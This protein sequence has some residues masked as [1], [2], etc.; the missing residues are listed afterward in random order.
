MTALRNALLQSLLT[1]QEHSSP[2]GI[3]FNF[4]DGHSPDPSIFFIRN[5]TSY[6]SQ[7]LQ[8]KLETEKMAKDRKIGVAMDFS[9]SSKNAL[10]WAID[11]LVDKGDTLFIIR[12][13]PNSIDES[14]HQL[15][16]KSGSRKDLVQ[17]FFLCCFRQILIIPVMI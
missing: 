12:I 5:K 8:K 9:K 4:F 16:A 1:S 11:N 14:H 6:K 17:H 3:T 2:L 7:R 10:K 15:W 13:N